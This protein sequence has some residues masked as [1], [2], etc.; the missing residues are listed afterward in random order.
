M[1]PEHLKDI[2]LAIKLVYEASLVGE[3]PDAMCLLGQMYQMGI[4]G[5]GAA[6]SQLK[7]D[8]KP[9]HAE[10]AA[11][12]QRAAMKGHAHSLF[13]LGVIHEYGLATEKEMSKAIKLFRQVN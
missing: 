7:F 9:R 13:N 11:W 6:Y 3:D 10:A 8:G 12:Y 5:T 4:K 1:G 2:P